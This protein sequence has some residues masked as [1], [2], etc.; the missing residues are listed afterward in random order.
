MQE[1][2]IVSECRIVRLAPD[3]RLA[4]GEESARS[5][6]Q[7]ISMALSARLRWAAQSVR[8][9]R[10]TRANDEAQMLSYTGWAHVVDIA[11]R[12]RVTQGEQS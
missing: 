6:G 5:E 3:F 10:R 12:A 4:E 1:S 2:G 8:H 11:V 7:I 9:A